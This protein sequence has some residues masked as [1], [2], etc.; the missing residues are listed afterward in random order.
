M[1]ALDWGISLFIF[2]I[3]LWGFRQGL[4]VGVLG[5]AGLAG[6]AVL[7]SRM[8]PIIL[9]GGS[10]SPYAPLTALI[11]A[12]LIGAFALAVGVNLGER[13]RDSAVNRSFWQ[14]M[15]GIGGALLVAAVGLGLIWVLGAV[16]IY[17]PGFGD[18]RRD[19]QKSL[20][21]GGINQ[22]MPPS[23]PLIQALHRIDPAPRI[24]SSPKGIPQPTAG[25]GTLPPVRT[26]ADSVVRVVGT[27]CGVGVMGSGWAVA[28]GVFVT[29][30][31]VVAGQGD[32]R[33]EANDG[34]VGAA[35]V[36]AFNPK[37]DVAVLRAPVS[38][39][40]LAMRSRAR[41]GA[42]AA[43]IGYPEN[44]PLTVIPARTGETRKVISKDA[45]GSGPVDR[46]ITT[47]RGAVRHGNSG[48]PVV[49]RRGQVV[50]TVFA[51]TT[52]GPAGGLAI[53]NRIVTR[54]LGRAA[55]EVSTG[56]CAR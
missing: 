4:I 41:R 11:G 24:V 56:P 28:P 18:L 30:A 33:V 45:Y 31:H 43:V 51:A 25:V 20:L 17:S 19:V 40:A 35:T 52:E 55:G 13:V 38:S 34:Q 49:D 46:V 8:A 27:A 10:T 12:S 16:A 48:G 6:G 1:T 39:P 50:G 21:L 23:G 44:G 26:S 15:D 22:V 54:I 53:P 32:T 14:I 47:L 9:E 3:A 42:A 2:L 7:G 36:V 29:N 37:N 5:L